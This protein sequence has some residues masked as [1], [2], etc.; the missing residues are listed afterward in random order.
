MCKVIYN[1]KNFVVKETN[2]D[3]IVENALGNKENH[4]HFSKKKDKKG[5]INLNAIETIINL[6]Q[7]KKKPRS[8]YMQKAAYRLTIDENY[9]ELLYRLINKESKRYI[10]INKGVR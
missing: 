9:K 6:V 1:N 4:A 3:L 7:N 5:K 10:N 2:R 8:K